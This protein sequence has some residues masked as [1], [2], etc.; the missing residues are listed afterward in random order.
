MRIK[1]GRGIALLCALFL[2]TGVAAAQNPLGSIAGTVFDQ[3]GGVIPGAS[4]SVTNEGTGLVVQAV[5]TNDE[6]VFTCAQIPAGAYSVKIEAEGF[7]TASFTQVNVEPGRQYS[8]VAKMEIGGTNEIVK[9]IAG[10]DLVNTTNAEI[11]NTVIRRQIVD[12]PLNGR[13]P[14][15]LIRLQAGVIGLPT[16]QTTTIN[17]GR[18]TWTQI[19]Q[20]GIN[21]QDNFIRTN[22]L[23]FVPNRP[24]SD[25]ISE[26]S[27]T[28]NTQ[29]ADAAG[30]ASQIKMVTPSGGNEFRG[31]V[32]EFN[33]NS[34]L[35]ANRWFNNATID[36][37][38]G[39]TIPRSFLNRNQFGGN[40]GGPV[41]LFGPLKSWTKDRLFFFFSYE[42]FRQRTQASQNN[43]IPVNDDFLNGVFKYVRPSDG[44]VQAVNVLNPGGTVPALAID[45]K[46]K[47][48]VLDRVPSSSL[49]NNFDVG[50]SKSDLLLNTAGYR[51]NQSDANNRDQ[52]AMR[53][54]YQAN[55][56]HRFEFIHQRFKETDDRTDLDTITKRPKVFTESDVKL[57]VGAWRW[58]VTPTLL[59]EVRVGA[60]IAPIAFE[61][62]EDFAGMIFNNLPFLTQREVTFQPQGRNTNTYQYSNT[63]SWIKG[64][65]SF[66]FG[67][68]VQQ[69]RVQPYNYA[70]R[71][72]L[73]NFGFSPVAPVD[74]QLTAANF[75]SG[76]GSAGAS[77]SATDLANANALRTFLGGVISM[78][79]QTFQVSSKTSGYVPG[80]PNVRNYAFDNWSIYMQD[81]WRL[82]PNLSLRYGLKWEYFT[83][84]REQDD[85]GLLPV[86]SASLEDSLR[87]PNGVVDF[88]EGGHYGKDL[89]NFG[90][91]FG[92]AWD[93]FRNGKTSVRFGYTLAFVNEETATVG[94]AASVA[95]SGLQ[96]RAQLPNLYATVSGGVPAV[97]VPTF[98]VP[99][100]FADQLALAPDS[101]AFAIDP[102]LKQPYV[103]QLSVAIERE[104]GWDFA[105]EGRY[106]ST[107]GRDIWRGLEYNQNNAAVN[108]AFMDDFQRARSNGFLALAATKIFNPA[109]EP[110]IAGSQQLTLIPTIGK[111]GLLDN[112]TVRSRIQ[113]GQVTGLADYYITQRAAGANALFLPNPGIYAAQAILNGGASDYHAFQA[114][115]RRRF[116]GGAFGQVN[117]SFSKVLSNS[118]GTAQNRYEP[119][120][121]NSRA[122][123]EHVRAEFDVTHVINGS[124][125]Y[126]LPFGPGKKLAAW[127]GPLGKVIGGWQVSSIVHYQSGSP[128]SILSG[129][130][131]FNR[132][133]LSANNPANT[134]LSRDQIRDLFGIQKLGDGR[135]FYIDPKVTDLAT[136][137][138]VAP[139]NLTNEPFAGQ[140]FFHPVAGEIGSLQR[141]QFDGPSQCQVDFSLKKQTVI[142]EDTNFELRA[143][144]FNFF[145]HPLFY[146][147]DYTLDSSQFGRI[148]TLNYGPRVVQIA[149]KLNF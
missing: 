93:P 143:D 67:G 55:E 118:V 112:A 39:K 96:S 103:H 60:N 76:P 26:F 41:K 36:K 101:V 145:N 84:L 92:V 120:L 22:S 75:P 117:Y 141:L 88:V 43:T 44:T 20:D 129:R 137:R 122:Y 69:I 27:I 17:G 66:Q 97:T 87:N 127:G 45:S 98:K 68:G 23:D 100:T 149:L 135:V 113:T 13:N 37:I 59:S 30:G 71:F 131:T 52:Y 21:I 90:P 14:I 85:I 121:D 114:E 99:R 62:S 56:G 15:E 144:F 48:L 34:A 80:I 61:N 133:G 105:V 1:T 63:T 148:T 16:R 65:H 130:G 102:N 70:A 10:T 51:F 72:P 89:N 19:T 83:P 109:Y 32:Y 126:E 53:F 140:V 115:L 82:K 50:N 146:V 110:K 128:I 25:T 3:S 18:P 95:N 139:D 29:G 132:I 4:I 106:V 58:M 79:D 116:S 64:S 28:T 147:G 123:L 33:R 24:T 107:M 5:I 111:A 134:T 11:A 42:G 86:I 12:L 125:I 54:D 94:R 38:T 142:R 31:S 77:I 57:I 40:I 104:I 81:A 6:G 74:Q 7:K 9:V 136:G 47:A 108:Q 124:M 138:A 91:S 49:A 78:V 73:V 35:G 2:V 119:Y 8:L 46:V